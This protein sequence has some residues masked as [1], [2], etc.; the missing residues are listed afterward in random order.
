MMAGKYIVQQTWDHREYHH[1]FDGITLT[2]LDT[3]TLKLMP[4]TARTLYRGPPLGSLKGR[5][6]IN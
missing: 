4:E 3:K 2:E 5:I 6:S 1:P